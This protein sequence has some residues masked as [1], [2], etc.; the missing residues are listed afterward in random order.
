M[1]ADGGSC[2]ELGKASV[3]KKERKVLGLWTCLWRVQSAVCWL[4][5]VATG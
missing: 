2:R 3:S 5:S 4:E 1:C